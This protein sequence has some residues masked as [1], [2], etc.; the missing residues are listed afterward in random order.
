METIQSNCFFT[1]EQRNFGVL[2][3]NKYVGMI[4][5][6]V[7]LEDGVVAQDLDLREMETPYDPNVEGSGKLRK[8]VPGIRL[9]FLTPESIETVME[10]LDYLLHKAKNLKILDAKIEDL[11][12]ELAVRTRNVLRYNNIET[13][14]QLRNLS[15]EDLMKFRN[16]GKW[17]IVDVREFLAKYN[18]YLKGEKDNN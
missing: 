1:D 3:G 15:K 8:D 16:F 18:L 10:S 9:V 4:E 13:V 12:D 5:G 2:F 14:R 11:T 17:S 7:T 6:S